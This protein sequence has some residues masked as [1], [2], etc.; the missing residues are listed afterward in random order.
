MLEFDAPKNKSSIIKVIGVGGG[1]SNAV[2]HMYKLG[3]EGV[4]FILCNT[5]AQ[6]LD[7]SPIPNKIQLGSTGLGAGSIPE[8]GRKAAEESV[9]DIKNQLETNTKMLFI[10]AGMGGGT[11]TGA[12]PVIA[13]AARELDILTVGIVTLPFSFEG[14]KRANQ[15]QEGIEEL[16]KHV[17]TLLI[18]NNDKLREMHGNL[19]L[20]EAFGKADYVLTT[21]AKGIAEI[22]TVVGHINVDFEDVKT[23]MKDSGKAIMASSLTE[24]DNRANEAAKQALSSPL[25]DDDDIKG[26]TNILLYITSG[27]DEISMDEVME[28][29]DYIKDEAG[30]DANI[31]WGTGIDETLGDKISVTL[32]ATDFNSGAKDQSK[33]DEK[34]KDNP[35]NI[36]DLDDSVGIDSGMTTPKLKN[37]QSQNSSDNSG[38]TRQNP[39]EPYIR[40]KP[41]QNTENRD[42]YGFGIENQATTD[43]VNKQQK[44]KAEEVERF[45]DTNRQ[46]QESLSRYSLK[47]LENEPAYLRKKKMLEMNSKPSSDETISRYDLDANDKG[48][49]LNKG[50]SY[51]HKDTD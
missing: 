13:A 42:R 17:D 44:K 25:L 6:A 36:S 15:A 12:A 26:A 43:Y 2:N 28:I 40:Q 39:N 3:I 38:H 45:E 20:S 37:R 9:E 11:G 1:G 35:V 24:G 7:S 50:N 31:I 29:T 21:A 32:I 34:N 27:N 16:R 14:R 5:D 46:R 48:I 8:V 19:R 51:L 22:I 30:N 33:H 49:N 41:T 18:I 23:V 4:D 47:E 10:T